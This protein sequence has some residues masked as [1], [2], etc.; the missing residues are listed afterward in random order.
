MNF[1][2]KYHVFIKSK[3]K[4]GIKIVADEIDIRID[5]E[6]NG[7]IITKGEVFIGKK[8]RYFGDIKSKKC[9]I[10]GKVFGNIKVDEVIYIKSRAE[11]QGD[12]E[13]NKIH[14]SGHALLNGVCKK[15]IDD[16]EIKEDQEINDQIENEIDNKKNIQKEKVEDEIE[17]NQKHILDQSLL[18]REREIIDGKDIKIKK[19]KNI[20]EDLIN[21]IKDEG[22]REK[23]IMTDNDDS[24]PKRRKLF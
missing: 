16:E 5:C 9:V 6:V 20:K 1:R 13:Y 10:Y 3:V 2:K 8:G 19:E 21:I 15:I 4:E 7:N 17:C 12:I 11:V 22:T 18:C 14:K 23:S 24:A